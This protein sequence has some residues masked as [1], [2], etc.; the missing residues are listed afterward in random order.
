MSPYAQSTFMQWKHIFFVKLLTD[1]DKAWEKIHFWWDTYVLFRVKSPL[2]NFVLKLISLRFIKI[3]IEVHMQFK[4]VSFADCALVLYYPYAVF[5]YSS[6]IFQ[7]FFDESFSKNQRCWQT[8]AEN[9]L[10]ITMALCKL[11]YKIFNIQQVSRYS[12][13]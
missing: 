7:R 9:I 5:S 10:N 13:S 6:V 8:L 2:L 3:L 4:L 11:T 1:V 12:R